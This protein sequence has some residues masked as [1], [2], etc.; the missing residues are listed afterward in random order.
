MHLTT[1]TVEGVEV[2]IDVNEKGIF[3]AKLGGEELAD[4]AIDRLERQI[5]AMIIARRIELPFTNANGNR[6]VMRGYHAGN[7]DI[8]I[9]WANGETGRLSDY[10]TVYLNADEVTIAS[11]RV[12]I[13]NA[14]EAL[15][16]AKDKLHEALGEG[17]RANE[18]FN[19]ALG[20]DLY[21]YVVFGEEPVSA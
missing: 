17:Q 8:L 3:S 2:E 4:E 20:V 7:H 11:A 15:K 19:E 21:K 13:K 9:T 6:G 14:A 18:V 16:S 5:K 12:E 10:E 1:L